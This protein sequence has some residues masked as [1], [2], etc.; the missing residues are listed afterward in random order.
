[1]AIIVSTI[2]MLREVEYATTA[3]VDRCA[4]GAVGAALA[5]AEGGQGAEGRPAGHQW[6]FLEAGDRSPLAGPAG[7]VRALA[8]RVH[9]LPAL[10]PRPGLG[11]DPRRGPA[12]GRRPRTTRLGGPVRGWHRRPSAP[13]S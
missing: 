3:R 12:A 9:A 8:E 1:M 7:A 5:A 2:R 11:P 10:D 13:A 6:H 4:V